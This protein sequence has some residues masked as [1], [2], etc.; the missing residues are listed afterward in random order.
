MG[1]AMVTLHRCLVLFVAVFGGIT[2]SLVAA[3]QE[4]VKRVPRVGLLANQPAAFKAYRGF[5]E[6][7]R[8]LGY[9]EGQNIAIEVISAQGQLDR[10][11]EL[12]HNLAGRNVDVILAGGEQGLMAAKQATSSIPI[13]VILCDNPEKVIEKLSRPGGKATGLT[14]ISSDLSSKRLEL[15]RDLVPSLSRVAVLYNA[16]PEKLIES[17]DMQRAARVLG[18]EVRLFEVQTVSDIEPAFA[19]MGRENVQALVILANAFMNAHWSRLAELA[20]RGR[21]P[22]IYG[23]REFAEAGGLL[24]YGASLHALHKDAARYVDKILKGADPGE[25]PVEQPTRFELVINGKTAQA[26]GLSVPDVILALTD[27]VLE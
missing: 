26:L 12:A 2:V 24:S 23:F 4:P 18:L 20:L 9:V 25:L 21:L 3:A 11:P 17:E 14:C 7:L 16:E 15:L 19:G 6:G 5:Y 1:E 10:L 8:E 13:V 27:E 22:A